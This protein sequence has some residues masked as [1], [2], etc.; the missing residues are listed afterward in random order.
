MIV[1]AS[2]IACLVVVGQG[3]VFWGFLKFVKSFGAYTES[4][5]S[6]TTALLATH[7]TNVLLHRENERI[8]EELKRIH[9]PQQAGAA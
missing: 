3:L 1:L 6:M 2:V 4:Y 9:R 7:E 5:R 8:L